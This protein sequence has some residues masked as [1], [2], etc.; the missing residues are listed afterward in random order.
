M[1]VRNA[2]SGDLIAGT[3]LTL[4]PNFQKT[5]RHINRYGL[6]SDCALWITPCH[7]IYTVGMKHSVD[8]VFLDKHGVVVKLLRCFPP[9]CYAESAS[10][11]ISALELPCNRISES[12]IEVGD[13][14]ELEP[15]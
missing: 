3:L 15:V 7:A 11:T 12:G 4:S 6:P 14:L 8:I 1:S 13:K 2:R 5:L 9:N 10:N